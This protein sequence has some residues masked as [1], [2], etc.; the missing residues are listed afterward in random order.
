MKLAVDCRMIGS[1]GIGT[2]FLSI[3]PYLMRNFE[4]IL[5]GD[6]KIINKS[7]EVILR[8]LRFR[9]IKSFPVM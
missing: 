6:E 4:C 8:N 3:L 1:G 5:F 2:Y 9:L 7:L